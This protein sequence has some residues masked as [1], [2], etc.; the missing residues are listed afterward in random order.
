MKPGLRTQLKANLPL[1]FTTVWGGVVQRKCAC[2]GSPGS[3]S[4]CDEC[5]KQ[6]LSLQR[7]TRDPE[8]E[9]RNLKLET[10]NSEAVL[11]IVDEALHSP[12][13]PLDAETRAFGE[14]R[15]SHDFGRVRVNPV[16]TPAVQTKLAIS[17]PGDPYEQEADRIAG[18]IM[19][20]SDP[21]P[22][23]ARSTSAA[24]PSI[25]RKPAG[26]SGEEELD[27]AVSN[28]IS[29]TGQPLDSASRAFFE[30]RFGHDFSRVR[31]HADDRAADSARA[32]KARAY[33]VGE[34]VVFGA[35]QFSPE[36]TEGR[37]LLAHELTHVIQQG[38]AD[39][40]V[41]LE[42]ESEMGDGT[43]DRKDELETGDSTLSPPETTLPART[44]LA[45]KVTPTLTSGPMLQRADCPCCADGLTIDNIRKTD[46]AQRIDHKFDVNFNL[47]YPASGPKGSCVLEWW[48][49]TDVPAVPGHKPNTWTE[50]Y[51][52]YPQSPTFDPWKNRA[53][54]CA[55]SSPV[56]IMDDPH[57]G[58][59]PGRTVTRTLEFK[60]KVNSM[61]ASSDSGCTAATQEVTAK[62]VL[63][64][65]NG[66]ADWGASSF[67]TP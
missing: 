14:P 50:L 18:Q 51:A 29:S 16:S 46:N 34:H 10:R 53:E 6:K 19:R 1:S 60:I 56:T 25:Q 61:P 48:E 2:G 45:R 11:P 37:S 8:I 42:E 20:M 52:L 62:Q 64:M 35:K 55:S 57:L 43:V 59:S 38:A 12:G 33:T 67:T 9:T 44:V 36:S 21:S 5:S 27:P 47:Q 54:T 24:A 65:V 31:V 15:F 63:V 7:S 41:A 30:P 28:V 17:Q 13:Q 39:S 49:K 32:V 26:E 22:A 58:K 40:T 3:A 66:A 23:A 4:E